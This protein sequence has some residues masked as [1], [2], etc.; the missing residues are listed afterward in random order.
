MRRADR[1]LKIVHFLRSRRRAVTAR[2]IAEE[3]DICTRTVY[4][5]IQ[6]LVY[7][8]APIQGE[9]GVGYIIDKQ[10]YLPPVTFDADELEAITLG[11]TMVRQWTD[12]NFAEKANNALDKIHAVLPASLQGELHQITTYSGP[13]DA[14]PPWQVSFSEVRECIRNR[15]KI[16]INYQDG[17]EQTTH[18]TVRPLALVF[19]SPVWLLAG[20]CEKRN[21]FRNFRLDRIQTMQISDEIFADEDDKN[22]QAYRAKEDCF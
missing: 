4:R 10:Y 7:S 13:V 2:R 6:D 19:F 17:I 20:W 15:R 14:V 9:A 3:F 12:E 8:G 11:I 1:L 18:R 5:D 16:S 22:L 21:D